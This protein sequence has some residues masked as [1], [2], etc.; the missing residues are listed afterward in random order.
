[1]SEEVLS[2]KDLGLSESTL[3]SIEEIG[4]KVPSPIQAQAIPVVLLGQ[5]VVGQAQTGTGKTA[6]FMLPIL[7]KIDPKNRN[8]QAL[9]LCPTRELAV[10]VHDEAKKFAKN[11]PEINLLSVYGGQSYDPQIRALKRGVQIVVGT[12]GRVMDHMKR[13]TLKLDHLKFMVLDE[14]DEM[15]NM[16]FKDDI[17]SIL[18]ETPEGRQTVL[19]SATMPAEILKIARTHQKNPEVIKVAAK[20]L[21]NR[22]IDQYYIEVK[23]RDRVQAMIRCIDAMG[24]TS[25]IVFTNTKR[26][27]DELVSKLQ[28]E[29][30][31]AE[32]LHGDLKQVQRDRVMHA[33][34]RKKVNILVAT[35]I[36][37]RGI[38]VNNIEAV[39]NYDIPLNEENYVHR[40]GRTGR[41]G[42]SGVSI[43]FVFGRDMFKLRRIE[44][45]TKSKMQKMPLPDAQDIKNQRINKFV[46]ELTANLENSDFSKEHEILGNLVDAGHSLVDV[47][48]SLLNMQ[49]GGIDK[50]Y[51]PIEE[52]TSYER[53][54]GRSGE[55]R[56]RDRRVGPRKHEVRLAFNIGNKKRMSPKELV[57]MISKNAN[58]PPRAVGD[59]D[60]RSKQTYVNVDKAFVG[61]IMKRLDSK[62]IDGIKLTV[63]KI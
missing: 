5:D 22:Q 7:E 21:S 3:K 45:Y 63:E 59:I 39:F 26:E 8:V 28:S 11:N 23:S 14:A 31:V 56:D 62:Y 9:I 43:T 13:R 24:I 4:Y 60:I 33:F 37:A 15:L 50:K 1:M 53:G 51:A 49:I 19:F 55:R 47:A 32:G 36:A 34:R 54:G 35:D 57:S 42:E 41:A 38:D 29:G 18:I 46:D 10:Q 40:I 17:E 44:A 61:Q 52:V 48:A 20:E 2:F 16:G 30:Y 12:P 27:V 6:A 25:S 58:V